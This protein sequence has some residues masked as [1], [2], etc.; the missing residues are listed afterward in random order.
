MAPLFGLP[1]QRSAQ[2]ELCV[3]VPWFELYK[4]LVLEDCLVRV[5][6][7]K[8]ASPDCHGPGIVGLDFQGFLP[9]SERLVRLPLAK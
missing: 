6:L 1:L 5:P 8:R 4:L 3:C 7:L 9:A 2:A